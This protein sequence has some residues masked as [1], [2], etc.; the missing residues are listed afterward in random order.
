MHKALFL[1]VFKLLTA[2]FTNCF[3]FQSWQH[4]SLSLASN[5]STE[6]KNLPCSKLIL[7]ASFG[8]LSRGWRI[9]LPAIF[10]KLK[11][12]VNST[13]RWKRRNA[14]WKWRYSFQQQKIWPHFI[15]FWPKVNTT[16]K[17]TIK[18]KFYQRNVRGSVYCISNSSF[19]SQTIKIFPFWRF[20]N[21][22]YSRFI[23]WKATA[24][25]Y[26]KL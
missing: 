13:F 3:V 16:F 7:V 22:F 21:Y 25:C 23:T 2:N 11:Y 5:S 24:H 6:M 20:V 15:I 1:Y 18:I 17:P 26:L 12:S 19:W 10:Y 4:I 8:S 14:W 9:E